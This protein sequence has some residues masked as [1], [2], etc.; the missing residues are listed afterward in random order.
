MPSNP[1]NAS[2]TIIVSGASGVIGKA[3]C[4]NLV[5]LD[6]DVIM[7]CRDIK[8]GEKTRAEIIAETKKSGITIE[9][10]DLSRISPIINLASRIKNPVYALVNNAAITPKRREVTAD[11]IEM[12]FAANVLNYFWMSLAFHKHLKKSSA[13]ENPARIVN[14][15]SYWAGDLSLGDLQFKM[16][17]YDNGTAYRQSKQA[18]RML[19][20][21][22]AEQFKDDGILVNAC[23]PGEVN[24]PLSNSMGFTGS[25]TPDQ[26]AKTPVWLATNKMHD[27]GKWFDNCEE[28]PCR[29]SADKKEINK[30]YEIC[31]DFSAPLLKS[32]K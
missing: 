11:G 28:Q 10:A 29:F 26:G 7:V 31:M 3:I 6:Y 23:H 19:S 20:V 16:R 13:P 32:V 8:K 5:A 22:L 2:K 17:H 27:T 18:N 21:A 25:Q 14:V 24:T 1:Q 15:A 30:L 4:K 12:Q 9:T